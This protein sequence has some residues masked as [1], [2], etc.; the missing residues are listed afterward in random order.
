MSETVS[1]STTRA[2]STGGHATTNGAAQAGA[3]APDAQ[4]AAMERIAQS[5]GRIEERLSRLESAVARAESAASHAGPAVAAAV[6]TFDDLVAGLQ[7]RGIDI[8][9]RLATTLGV[10]ERLT[11]PAALGAVS[12]LLD[13]TEEIQAVLESG[14]LDKTS[15][16]V[17]AE[18][19]RALAASGRGAPERVG[20]FGALRMMSD[21]DV[22]RALGFTLRLAQSFGAATRKF[23]PGETGMRA[24]AER[25][26]VEP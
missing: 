6:D 15:V 21:P 14:V 18:L 11:S 19:G 16:A 8:D 9:E 10:A 3:G 13:R 12:A 4:A 22:Q 1:I 23:D 5:L 25:T 7:A 20:I 24:L 17:V 2:P 26:E